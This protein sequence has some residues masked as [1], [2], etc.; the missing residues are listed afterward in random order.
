MI[1]AFTSISPDT[2]HSGGRQ[3][4]TIIGTDFRLSPGNVEAVRVEVNGVRSF[5]DTI[6]TTELRITVP[7]FGGEGAAAAADPIPAVDVVITN[8]DDS[9]APIGGEVVTAVGAYTY[10]RAEIRPPAATLEAQIYRRVVYEVVH[11]F[12]RQIVPNVAIGTN[13]DFGEF[14]QAVIKNAENPSVT[15]LGPRFEEDLI[16]RHRWADFFDESIG[17]DPEQ[18]E[19]KWPGYVSTL[20]FDAVLAADSKREVWA[21]SQALIEMFMRTPYLEIPRTPGDV[22]G[23]KLRFPFELTGAPATSIQD[24]NSNLVTAVSVFEVRWVPFRITEATAINE[25]M[26]EGEFQVGTIP[27]IENAPPTDITAPPGVDVVP[28]ATED[29]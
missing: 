28:F 1:P 13:I 17:G 24:P 21:M 20:E 29:P 9:G 6:T 7:A 27:D 3:V 18:F 15:L 16:N 23:E 26:L 14:G 10:A 2:G 8:L 22:N 11:S 12:Q 25:E 5:V 19:Q 4:A